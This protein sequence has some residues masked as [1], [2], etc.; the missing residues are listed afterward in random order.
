[1]DTHTQATTA[2]KSLFAGASQATLRQAVDGFLQVEMVNRSPQTARWYKARLDSM[3]QAIGD[4]RPLGDVLEVDLIAYQV[5]L[6]NRQ[7][8]HGSEKSSRKKKVDKPLSKFSLHGHVRAMR[9]FFKWLHT[10]GV[11]G[12]DLSANLELPK[13]PKQGRK[14]ISEANL[15]AILAAAQGNIR[16]Y[17]IIS[18]L[19]STAARRGGVADLRLSDLSLDETDDRLRRRASVREKGEKERTVILSPAALQA[20]EAWL[21]V[22]PAAPYDHVFLGAVGD[23]WHPLKPRGISEIIRRYKDK[24][25]LQGPCSPHQFRHRWARHRLQKGMEL[26]QVSQ[27]LGH[28]DVKVTIDFYGQFNVDQLQD[29]Y[30]KF[31]DD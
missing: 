28:Q 27:L 5:Q 14:G 29:T 6:A 24:L 10:R 21:A 26:G 23:F 7:Q 25:G 20:L 17:A 18:F 1:M 12:A 13:L 2:V 16:D 22:R 4:D 11:L 3:V 8:M 31:L 19:E 30:D 15:R 9:R